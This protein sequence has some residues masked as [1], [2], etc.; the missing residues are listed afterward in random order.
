MTGRQPIR[1]DSGPRHIGEIAE[2]VVVDVG[3][4]AIA[5]NLA[6]GRLDGADGIR[7]TL[8]LSWEQVTGA[9]GRAA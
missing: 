1:P 3:F 6:E 2:R 4:R 7:H 8:G 5:H 9:E